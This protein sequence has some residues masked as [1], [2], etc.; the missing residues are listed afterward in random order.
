MRIAISCSALRPQQQCAEIF[1]Q[2]RFANVRRNAIS[3]RWCSRRSCCPGAVV[4]IRRCFVEAPGVAPPVQKRW[5][6]TLFVSRYFN[7]ATLLLGT[8]AAYTFACELWPQAVSRWNGCAFSSTLG[9]NLR[10]EG[11]EFQGVLYELFHSTWFCRAT[12]WTIFIDAVAWFAII[13][14]RGGATALAVSLALLAAQSLTFNNARFTACSLVFYLALLAPALNYEPLADHGID[15]VLC[16]AFLRIIGHIFEPAPPL[17]FDHEPQLHFRHKDGAAY[18]A[19][20]QYVMASPRNALALIWAPAIGLV[21]ELQAGLPY[22][23]LHYAVYIVLQQLLGAR[24]DAPKGTPTRAHIIA[25]SQ[26]IAAQGWNAWEVTQEMY[27][28]IQVPAEDTAGSTSS[29]VCKTVF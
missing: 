18:N 16:D 24:L 4:I 17:M 8:L 7:M 15:I 5:A 20:A 19:M 10:T 1:L 6:A 29:T 23:L 13:Y 9:S 28:F 22:R 14:D 21:S 3:P 27:Q 11:F 25:V 26:Q 12:H 2:A